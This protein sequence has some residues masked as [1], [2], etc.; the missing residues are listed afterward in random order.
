VDL[1]GK[2]SQRIDHVLMWVGKLGG[3]LAE[4]FE[5]NEACVSVKGRATPCTTLQ[6][7]AQRVVKYRGPLK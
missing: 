4:R 6:I 1:V 2:T 7:A 3:Y 5:D